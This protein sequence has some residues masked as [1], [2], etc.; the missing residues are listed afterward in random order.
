MKQVNIGIIGAGDISNKFADACKRVETANLVAVSAR[1]KE[2]AEVFA[3][4]HGIPKAY[5]N[6]QEL[7]ND[8]EV[9]A[10]YIGVV[11]SFHME[12]IEMVAKAGKAIF[13]EKP[14]LMEYDHITRFKAVM[15]ETD[16]LFMEGVWTIH[17]P[18]I[19]KAKEWIEEGKI[20]KLRMTDM[21]FCFEGDRIERSRLF[22][23]DLYGGGLI[24][25]GVYCLA[26]TVLM[27]GNFPIDVQG[28][29][30]I[31]KDSGVDEYGV[32]T[33]RFPEDII[34]TM[35]FGVGFQRNQHSNLYG[36]KGRIQLK[37][38]WDCS[39]I[40]LYNYEDE[41]VETYTNTHENGFVYELEHFC[42]LYLTGKKE[43]DINTIEN[44][45]EYV[46]VYEKVRKCR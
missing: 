39:V 31:G 46:E 35:H 10:V 40:E 19:R 36:E 30:Y 14:A 22:D 13:C 11:N 9:Q 16:V 38:F 6:Y 21:N 17:L 18:A 45:I 26:V 28:M 33:M 27:T 29:E 32:A 2:K 34:G 42:E 15:E 23:K 25:V 41:L 7:V 37:E 8:E 24:D 1:S 44:T 4:T 20:G 3:E 12:L 5:G 43:S